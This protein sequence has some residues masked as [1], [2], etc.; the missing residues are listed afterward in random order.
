MTA[1]RIACVFVM[2]DATPE[3]LVE[4]PPPRNQHPGVPLPLDARPSAKR[5]GPI[6]RIQRH[7]VGGEGS[8]FGTCPASLLELPLDGRARE[9]LAA[10]ARVFAHVDM[11]RA[12]ERAPGDSSGTST[13]VLTPDYAAT[14]KG[15]RHIPC[16]TKHGPADPCPLDQSSGFRGND[17][18]PGNVAE[19]VWEMPECAD[20]SRRIVRT[21]DGWR[22]RDGGLNAMDPHM[23][24]PAGGPILGEPTRCAHPGCGV[25]IVTGINL[26]TWEHSRSRLP[27]ESHKPPV[28]Y[29]HPAR[30]PDQGA[31]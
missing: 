2:C 17:L 21:P 24:R 4:M 11:Q 29:D 22:H 6:A 27:S 7:E 20:C 13:S 23:A 10:Q 5:P 3:V 28:R 25:R 31:S 12:T 30:H 16:G 1:R 8:W 26:G 19:R 15:L 14:P 18:P 9:H